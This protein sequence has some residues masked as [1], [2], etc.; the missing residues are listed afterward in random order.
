MKITL[1]SPKGRVKEAPT[2]F[3]LTYLLFG[4]LVPLFRAY[5]LEFIFYVAFY[6]IMSYLIPRSGSKDLIY[7]LP[8]MMNLYGAVTYNKRYIKGLVQQWHWRAATPLDIQKLTS[9]H[10]KV[11][12]Q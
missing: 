9:L 4:P 5:W 10:I 8:G 12:K 11:G 1:I 3:S 6:A 7:Y 2:G